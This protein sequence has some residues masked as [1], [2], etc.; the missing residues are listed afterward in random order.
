MSY[1]TA[2]PYKPYRFEFNFDRALLKKHH[3]T[4]LPENSDH[5]TTI[6][7]SLIEK[8]F[9]GL[10]ERQK[11]R[12]AQ[13]LLSSPFCRRGIPYREP[14]TVEMA[15]VLAKLSVHNLELLLHVND[16]C[17]RMKHLIDDVRKANKNEGRYGGKINVLTSRYTQSAA[18]LFAT[19]LTANHIAEF[20]G[21]RSSSSP[22]M[23]GEAVSIVL[24]NSQLSV[25]VSTNK[26]VPPR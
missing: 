12:W 10:T 13:I 8:F 15:L 19:T 9:P 3:Y 17:E 14:T 7:P 2:F 4:H 18:T 16:F 6:Q 11:Q 25:K 20:K 21:E 22:D 23:F 1:I 26:A 24:A 5:F